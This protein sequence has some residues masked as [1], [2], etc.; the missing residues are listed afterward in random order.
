MIKTHILLSLL[1]VS[2]LSGCG[3]AR[4]VAT[5]QPQVRYASSNIN[6][7]RNNSAIQIPSDASSYFD[8]K[9]KEELMKNFSSGNDLTLKYRFIS[10]QEGDRLKR[11]ISGGIGNWGEAAVI[12]EAE[13]FD[14]QGNKLGEIQIDG[15]ISSGIFG[16]GINYAL[17]RI[18]TELS[19]YVFS[20]FKK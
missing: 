17:D 14:N 3:T 16:G 8:E 5:D 7:I 13:F 12:I 4:I 2:L 20:N 19:N 10:F 1:V 11:Y 9:L 18:V 6:I 15:K